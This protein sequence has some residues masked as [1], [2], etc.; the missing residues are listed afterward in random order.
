MK[1]EASVPVSP[2]AEPVPGVPVT[3]KEAEDGK[4]VECMC[5]NLLQ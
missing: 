3:P 1:D 2:Q 5:D 4:K